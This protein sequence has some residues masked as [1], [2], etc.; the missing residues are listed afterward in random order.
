MYY[1]STE[2]EEM[3]YWSQLYNQLVYELSKSQSVS[4]Q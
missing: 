3:S 4:H 2:L 1:E